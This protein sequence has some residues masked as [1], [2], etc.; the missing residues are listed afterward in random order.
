MKK[1]NIYKSVVGRFQTKGLASFLFTFCFAE[2]FLSIGFISGHNENMSMYFKYLFISLLAS[3]IVTIILM[4][5]NYIVKIVLTKIYL[6]GYIKNFYLSFKI[7]NWYSEG[8]K[9]YNEMH[10]SKKFILPL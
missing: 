5:I 2:F 3:L 1:S 8:L 9:W 4:V 10:E 6:K 7:G